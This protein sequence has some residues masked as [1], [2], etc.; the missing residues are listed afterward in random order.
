MPEGDS[1]AQQQLQPRARA[2][3]SWGMLGTRYEVYGEIASGGM[4]T[5]QYGRLIGPRGFARAV[6]IKRMHPHFAREPDFVS[7]FVDEARLSA[8][9]VHANII[10]TLDVV[11]TPGELALVMEYVHGEALSTLL[12]LAAA[13][14]ERVPVRV[15]CALI[16]SVLYG[17]HAAH[18]TRND[19]GH[20]L[21]IVH[22]DVSPQNILV[23]ADGIPRVLDFGIAKAIGHLRLTPSGEIKGKLS[24]ISPEQLEGEGVDRR[25]D[26]YGASAVL[27]E[28]L[29]GRPL[30]EGSTESAIL[31][32]VLHDVIAPPSALQPACP[33]AL[34]AIVMR[35]L[36]RDASA[37]FGTAREMAICLER[38]VGLA[39]QSEVSDWLHALAGRQLAARAEALARMQEGASDAPPLPLPLPTKLQTGPR[40]LEFS[41]S[42]PTPTDVSGYA[43]EHPARRPLPIWPWLSFGF[44]LLCATAWLLAQRAQPPSAE[45][46]LVQPASRASL[47]PPSAASTLSP[48]AASSPAPAEMVS[49]SVVQPEVIERGI[50]PPPPAAQR[51]QVK[52]RPPRAAGRSKPVASIKAQCKPY[53]Y[54]DELGIRRPKPGCL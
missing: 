38:D 1:S 37:R 45:A 34:D 17:L 30:F 31:H 49:P 26:I 41:E 44:A 12:R 20:P 33:P 6:A 40:K 15:A 9:L 23:G 4:A 52:A 28:T 27:W 42:T 47:S 35:G 2:A 54:I 14:G 21:H 29:T 13:E 7:M 25:A 48:V 43:S 8:R 5:V 39:T 32:G 22:R 24:Y 3:E 36:S 51:N 10:P 46:P 53:Y 18:E 50:A 11:E 19:A 16:A